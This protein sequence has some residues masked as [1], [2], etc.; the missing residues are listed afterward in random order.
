MLNVT[1]VIRLS[2]SGYVT[3]IFNLILF[4]NVYMRIYLQALIFI[5]HISF[6]IPTNAAHTFGMEHTF[7]FCLS[8]ASWKAQSAL[9]GQLA[10]SCD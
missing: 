2:Q 4:F 6:P 3:L 8:K 10:H 7:S 9:I 1:P 5:Q